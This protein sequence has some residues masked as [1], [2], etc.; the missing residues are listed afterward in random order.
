MVGIE[1]RVARLEFARLRI[2]P[3]LYSR[4]AYG[5]E[6]LVGEGIRRSGASRS[7]IFVSRLEIRLILSNLI[8]V[9]LF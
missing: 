1:P 7:D 9:V 5:N 8:A 6:K 2:D 3:E 4:R